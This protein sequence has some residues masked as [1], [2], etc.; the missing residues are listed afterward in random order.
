MSRGPGRVQRG[1]LTAIYTADSGHWWTMA[2]L[3]TAVF[4]R[5]TSRSQV[6][7]VRRAVKALATRHAITTDTF[8]DMVPVRGARIDI[9]DR[10][11]Y[12]GRH[13][14]DRVQLLATRT[15]S[16]EEKRRRDEFYSDLIDR[17]VEID[18]RIS[19]AT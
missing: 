10:Y 2:E 1:V 17:L 5:P 11:A 7:S 13:Y 15:L 6:E 3:A 12:R 19:H 9:G 18:S 4:G 8:P 16:V 14:A